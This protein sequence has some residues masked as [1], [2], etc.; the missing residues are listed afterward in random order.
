MKDPQIVSVSG[1][2]PDAALV[3]WGEYVIDNT[4]QVAITPPSPYTIT[5]D[6]NIFDVTI[7]AFSI[8]VDSASLIYDPNS[9]FWAIPLNTGTPVLN[10]G[11]TLVDRHKYVARISEHGSTFNMREFYLEEFAID[12][13]SF[14]SALMRYPFEITNSLAA[15][16]GNM[17]IVWYDTVAHFGNE[18]YAKFKAPAYEGGTGINYATDASRVTHRGPIAPY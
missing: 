9:K 2:N 5:V 3:V 7:G 6:I 14:E 8:T 11:T 15:L 16:S 4:T 1:E 10:N 18:T 12:D 17:H 13:G